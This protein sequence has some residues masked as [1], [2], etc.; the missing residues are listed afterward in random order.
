[1][2]VVEVVVLNQ[3]ALPGFVQAHS[4]LKLDILEIIIAIDSLTGLLSVSRDK[5][6]RAQ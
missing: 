5:P 4:L 6:A 3:G 1:M 2:V